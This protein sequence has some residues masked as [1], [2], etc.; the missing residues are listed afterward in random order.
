MSDHERLWTPWRMR[1]IA[2]EAKEDGCIF[3]NRLAG[4][5]DVASLILLRGKHSF[6]IMNLFPYNTG[7]IMIVPNQHA[8]D[9]GE[10]DT[11]TVHEMA[12]FLPVCTRALRR[13]LNCDGFNV[14]FNVGDVAGAGI[15]AHLHQHVVPRWVGDANFMPIIASTVAMP[16]LIP[17]TYA[18]TRL[19]LEREISGDHPCRV[20]LLLHDDQD[21][22]LHHNDL[23]EVQ[24]QPDVPVWLTAVRA[25]PD[26]ITDLEIAGWGGTTRTA[27]TWPSAQAGQPKAGIVMRG[28]VGTEIDDA[29]RA[30]MVRDATATVSP[31]EN[32]GLLTNLAALAPSVAAPLP[33][34]Q[35][36]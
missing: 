21:L 30:V 28:K 6:V 9:P 15:A 16:E 36:G 34:D 35:F 27:G 7:H 22:L 5:D 24:P 13:V 32:H 20:L 29:Y 19:E 11:A 26:G 23:P 31:E 8:A 4:T 12:E 1:Y 3:C 14:G 17:V 33:G 25:V 10:L 2:G 18:K